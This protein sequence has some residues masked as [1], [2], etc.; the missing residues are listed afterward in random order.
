MKICDT[1]LIRTKERLRCL[2]AVYSFSI[3]MM[4]QLN[5]EYSD[6]VILI[7]SMRTLDGMQ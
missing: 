5:L 3:R 4:I 7:E 1:Q 6:T 2:Y